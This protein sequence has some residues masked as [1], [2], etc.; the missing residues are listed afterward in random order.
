MRVVMI[1]L[2]ALAGFLCLAPAVQAQSDAL[3]RRAGAVD[4]A[5]PRVQV[6][7]DAVNDTHG[8]L[9]RVITTRPR[10]AT[11]KLAAIFVAGWLSCD[12]VEAPPGTKDSTSL[13]F[14]RLAQLP[15]FVLV[16]LDKPGIG[17]SQGIC[18][19]TDFTTELDGYRAAFKHMLGYDFVD[20]A[21]VF[22]FGTSN[23]GGFAPLVSDSAPVKGY[24][25]N[26]AWSKTWFEHM[27][28]IE[29]RRLA[30]SG[31]N[32]E[33]VNALMRPEAQFYEAYLVE[34]KAPR[35]ILA[36]N[37]ALAA[38]WPEPEPDHQYGR[39]TAFYQQLQ[40]LNLEAAWSHVA[41]P[42]LVLHGQYDWIMSR[43]DSELIVSL[44][45][46]NRPGAA[47]L[48]DLPA[49]D[50][51]FAHFDSQQAA[52]DGK[53]GPFDRRITDRIAAWFQAHR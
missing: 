43:G 32:P 6:I 18:G 2:A 28:E 15:G 19:D 33:E 4:E 51:N 34:G 16:R 47:A 10:A 36:A 5:Y 52:F 30:L 31:K 27:L 45:N 20:P 14:Q 17:D 9:L 46:R 1:A 53:P 3:P 7:Y 29:R 49:T 26:G 13:V 35:A 40:A 38:I 37:P 8:H 41:V 42:V 22:V 12:S 11:G 24:L 21:R 48:V 25:L 23:G 39:P 44:V 50:H